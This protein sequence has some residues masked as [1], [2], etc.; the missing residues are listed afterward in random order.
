[1]IRSEIVSTFREENPEITIRV[2]TN[3]VLYSWLKEGNKEVCA[4]TR[5]IVGQDGTTISTSE[6]DRYFDL[7]TKIEGFMDIDG[8]PGGGVTYNDKRLDMKSIAQLDA[9][10]PNWRSQ[11]SGIPKAY[12]R[13]GKWIYLDRAIDSNAEDIKVYAV[14]IPD[15]ISDNVMPFNQL[16]YLEPYHYSLVYYLQKRAKMKIGKKGAEIKAALEYE[17]YIK[18]MKT[19]LGG[20]KYTKKSYHPSSAYVNNTSNY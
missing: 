17:A 18:W 4:K 1:M 10:K 20:G 12:Y 11:S 2:L 13:R 7:S 9:E 15:D 6:G 16:S 5:C 8:Y 3:V 14:L 19:V